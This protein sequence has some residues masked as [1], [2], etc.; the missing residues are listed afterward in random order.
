MDPQKLSQ[1][2]PKLRDAYQR[3]MGT[4]IPDPPV[5]APQPTPQ[6]E[7]TPAP[8]AEPAPAIEEPAVPPAEPPAAPS[9][10]QQPISEPELTI[11]PQPQAAN[12]VQM[13][14]E[15]SAAPDVAAVPDSNF[16]MP[17]QAQ[18][19]TIK[20]KSNA[21]MPILFVIAGVVFIVIYALFWTKVFNLKLPFLG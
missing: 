14:S 21:L 2:D 10:P 15:I 16:A 13:N 9:I 7:P 6:P 20:K 5:P 12:F 19:A 1:L 11:N 8:I 3:V 18:T 17:A 4:V